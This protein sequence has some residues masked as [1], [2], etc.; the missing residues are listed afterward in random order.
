MSS[1][2]GFFQPNTIY[3]KENKF[4]IKTIHDMS[5]V[6]IHRGPDEQSFY[7][8]PH[9]AFNQNYLLAGYIPGTFPHQIQPL[10]LSYR[11]NT[12]TLLFDGF[13]TN[14]EDLAID[15]EIRQISTKGFSLE[16]ILLFS[17]FEKGIDFIKDLRGG[18]AL[19]IYD[20]GLRN[21]YLFRDALGLKPL[22]YTE[23]AKTFIFASEIK[24]LLQHPGVEPLLDRDGLTELLA[25]G[26][27]RRPGNAI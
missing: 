4:C 24:G 13:I 7:Y 26:P 25:L 12:Y 9:G 5:N 14:A 1:I 20:E 23:A 2:A 11:G 22:F 6:L 18:F 16:K 8:F 10:T 3:A 27:A 21:L 15:L 19:A 17:F